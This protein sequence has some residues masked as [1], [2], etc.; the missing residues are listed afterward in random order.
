MRFYSA[1]YIFLICGLPVAGGNNSLKN[2]IVHHIH[3]V[4]A[5][6]KWGFNKSKILKMY[7]RLLW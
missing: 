3:D 4:A 6:G 1:G 5:D 2:K 7:N